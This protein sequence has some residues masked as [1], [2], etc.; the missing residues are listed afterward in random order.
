MEYL[1]RTGSRRPHRSSTSCSNQT[2]GRNQSRKLRE[3]ST[4][5]ELSDVR[6]VQRTYWGG[7]H[8]A[9]DE[10]KGPVSGNRKPQ[11]QSWISYPVGRSTFPSGRCDDPAE[12]T[13]KGRALYRQRKRKGVLSRVAEAEGRSGGR[14]HLSQV[15]LWEELPN[16]R[17]S[18]V[19]VVL[20]N[21]DPEDE[22]DWPRQHQWL[23]D[24][25]NDFHRVF[26]NRVK[27]L[28]GSVSHVPQND[29][30]AVL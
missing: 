2:I 16:R 8:E 5:P 9:L 30:E 10:A 14:A 26:A 13:G 11:P 6:L 23:A 21:V 29:S 18:R 15:V 24:K 4:N 22:T 28:D 7:L 17:D 3:R 12:A 1:W 19:S 25:L 27:A 20:N